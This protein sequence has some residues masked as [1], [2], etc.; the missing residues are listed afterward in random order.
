MIEISAAWKNK[1]TKASKALL[2]VGALAG[3][4]LAIKE[5]GEIFFSSQPD[6][7]D[8]DWIP[9]VYA[10]AGN[11]RAFLERNDG[12]RV[13]INSAIALDLVLPVNSLVH[14]ACEMVLPEQDEREMG[15]TFYSIGLPTFSKDFDEVELD[16]AT[17]NKSNGDLVFPSSV[18]EKI[19]CLD[20]VRF[21]LIDPKSFRWSYG[22]T[23]TQS[24]PLSGTF[25][26][27]L[28]AFSGPR[29]EYTLRQVA[30]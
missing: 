8:E 25:K 4:I 5:L 13:Q 6:A 20:T 30:E 17:Y 14:Q 3:A 24:L 19:K 1:T 18:L 29:T 10:D 28:R 21:E 12:K 11:F 22:G 27:T 16:S 26:V 2:A 9:L 7:Y 15:K 23:G